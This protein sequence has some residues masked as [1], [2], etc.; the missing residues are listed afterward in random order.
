M[1]P[2]VLQM[3]LRDLEDLDTKVLEGIYFQIEALLK[4]RDENSYEEWA[5]EVS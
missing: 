3:F 4:E 1:K 5:D 2:E